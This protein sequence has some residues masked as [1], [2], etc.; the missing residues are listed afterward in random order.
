MPHKYAVCRPGLF[1]ADANVKLRQNIA[2]QDVHKFCK[3]KIVFKRLSYIKPY[4]SNHLKS[5]YFKIN[6]DFMVLS[7][8]KFILL[9]IKICT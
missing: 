3:L 9:R 1:V 8:T 5:K 6:A 7:F 4:S 2:L